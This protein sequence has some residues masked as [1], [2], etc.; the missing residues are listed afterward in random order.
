MPRSGTKRS[1]RETVVTLRL[2]RELHEL[3][4]KAADDHGRGFAAEVRRQ[5]EAGISPAA[6]AVPDNAQ[7]RGL[8]NA[9]LAMTENLSGELVKGVDEFAVFKR[10]IEML[11]RVLDPNPA[12]SD[13]ILETSAFAVAVLGINEAKLPDRD[14]LILRLGAL[15]HGEDV[16][17]EQLQWEKEQ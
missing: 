9:I 1:E 4:K 5:L 14:R 12:P 11:L 2:P 17:I 6:V 3:L 7:V 16:L 10:A 15:S 13:R 8:L